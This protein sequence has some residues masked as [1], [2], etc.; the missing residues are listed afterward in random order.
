MIMTTMGSEYWPK[1]VEGRILGWL[2]SALA[3]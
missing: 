3:K 1:T 2:L